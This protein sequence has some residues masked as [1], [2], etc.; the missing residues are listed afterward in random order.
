MNTKRFPR[1]RPWR[2]DVASCPFDTAIHAAHLKAQ[3]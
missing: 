1:G 2:P 3:G